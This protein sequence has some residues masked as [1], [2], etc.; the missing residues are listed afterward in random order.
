V[1][2]VAP[3]FDIELRADTPN[4]FRL[5]TFRGKHPAQKKQIPLCTA[6]T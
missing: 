3:R 2:R 4:E 5:V 1:S 6:S